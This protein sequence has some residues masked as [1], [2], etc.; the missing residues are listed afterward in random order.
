MP[1]NIKSY[2]REIRNKTID[3]FLHN[4]DVK[5]TDIILNHKRQ[6]DFIA[7]LAFANILIDEIAERMKE[8]AE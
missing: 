7:G 4:A 3:E 6:L 5:I 2:E 1:E 8:D